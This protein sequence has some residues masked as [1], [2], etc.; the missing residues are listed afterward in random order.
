[1]EQLQTPA[2]DDSDPPEDLAYDIEASHYPDDEP[3]AATVQIMGLLAEIA[4]RR[5]QIM[6]RPEPDPDHPQIGRY[7][8]LGLSVE[9]LIDCAGYPFP[10]YRQKLVGIAA[11]ALDALIAFD[12]APVE[13]GV[14][15]AGVIDDDAT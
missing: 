6:G 9:C 7:R 10:D 3:E 8:E 15:P 1:M 14:V 13:T 5:R 4:H 2:R 11:L 12:G